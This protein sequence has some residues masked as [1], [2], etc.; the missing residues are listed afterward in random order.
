MKEQSPKE[1]WEVEKSSLKVGQVREGDTADSGAPTIPGAFAVITQVKTKVLS[2][3][4]GKQSTLRL[5]VFD[6]VTDFG[7]VRNMVYG[8]S[9]F[10]A[11][12]P[13]LWLDHVS[14]S[15]AFKQEY[16]HIRGVH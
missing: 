15:K 13:K 16:K 10:C 9:M 2:T 6:L 4:S 3:N 8:E 1:E 11:L 5:V 7:I 14:E 12:Y